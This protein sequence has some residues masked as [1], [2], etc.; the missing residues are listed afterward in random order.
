MADAHGFKIVTVTENSCIC[1]SC[2][3]KDKKHMASFSNTGKTEALP[4]YYMDVVAGSAK[5]KRECCVCSHLGEPQD[6]NATLRSHGMTTNQANWFA[7]VAYG[8]EGDVFGDNQKLCPRHYQHMQKRLPNST[9]PDAPEDG[10]SAS[11]AFRQA[12]GTTW[13]GHSYRQCICCNTDNE[14][15]NP[16]S[17]FL[18][19]EEGD[20]TYSQVAAF[21]RKAHPV[22]YAP[23]WTVE[24]SCGDDQDPMPAHLEETSM[25][26]GKGEWL[27]APCWRR[28]TAPATA[29]LRHTDPTSMDWS[30]PG[31]DLTEEPAEQQQHQEQAADV[32]EQAAAPAQ[33]MDKCIERAERELNDAASALDV[34]GTLVKSLPE[35]ADKEKQ[36][37][38]EQYLRIRAARFESVLS[39]LKIIRQRGSALVQECTDM[40]DNKLR[41]MADN[42]EIDPETVADPVRYRAVRT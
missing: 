15:L 28:A 19:G 35:G 40:F 23:T 11:A 3:D 42:K 25:P 24:F 38:K 14:R 10:V 21:V 2:F 37:R 36:Q 6:S 39:W 18:A 41:D 27:C 17:W 7:G 1:R 31:E 20:A 12:T 30:P 33:T 16:A 9:I 32:D 29:E 13:V 4:Q 34:Q 5:L 8:M 26:V 22:T